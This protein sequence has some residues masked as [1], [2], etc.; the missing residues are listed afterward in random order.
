MR[1]HQFIAAIAG[2]ATFL[3][4]PLIRHLAIPIGAVG[5]VRA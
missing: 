3:L 2:G 4:T 5:T 1:V